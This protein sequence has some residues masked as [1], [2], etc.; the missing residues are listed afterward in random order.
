MSKKSFK[1]SVYFR[2]ELNNDSF[3]EFLLEEFGV[4]EPIF[5]EDINIGGYSKQWL[6]KQLKELVDKDQI[7][8]FS[9]GTY[10]IPSITRFG[11]MPLSPMQVITKKYLNKNG[12]STGFLI[13]TSLKNAAGLSNQ[14]PQD[15]NILTNNET[16]RIRRIKVGNQVVTLR[17]SKVKINNDNI[18]TIRFFE[19]MNV[20]DEV[21]FEQ[22]PKKNLYEFIDSLHTDLEKINE[23]I[24]NYSKKTVEN[25]ISSG[26]LNEIIQKHE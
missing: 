18:D 8:K 17:Q 7:S 3:F 9:R 22:F 16:S 25:M 20:I 4:D 12:V 11:K 24:S 23:Y 13:G 1:K 19:L 10:Y 2:E 6:Y 14:V 26:A 21:D 15:L 5:I